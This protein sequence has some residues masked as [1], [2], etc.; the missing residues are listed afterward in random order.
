MVEENGM[1]MV[2]V[3]AVGSGVLAVGVEVDVV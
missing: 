1:S 3:V 2:G